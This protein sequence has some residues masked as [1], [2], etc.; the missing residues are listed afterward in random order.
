MAKPSKKPAVRQI[1]KTETVRER[2]E[3]QDT[4]PVSKARRVKS[5]AGKAARPFKAAGRAIA[6]VLAPFAFL[7]IPFKTKPA[8][9]L[10]SFLASIL[11]L[12]FFRDSWKELRLVQW[13]NARE[14]TRLTIAVFVF[15]IVFG[16]I[17]SVVD[18]GL[19]KVFKKL[20][21]D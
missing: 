16:A 8:R 10:G 11:L 4:K 7:L 2:S 15:A 13:P 3:R 21:I 12:R 18:F 20:F 19:D 1:K 14:T 6:K 5:T 17:V 9:K